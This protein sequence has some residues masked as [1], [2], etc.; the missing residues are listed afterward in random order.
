[1]NE[2]IKG[3]EEQLIA[4]TEQIMA[5]NEEKTLMAAISFTPISRLPEAL[6]P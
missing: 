6:C 5:R 2:T 1:M 4:L 3:F